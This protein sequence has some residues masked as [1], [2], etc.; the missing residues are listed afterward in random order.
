MISRLSKPT[1][2]II[3]G[4][5]LS[6]LAHCALIW[7][8]GIKF[9]VR[10]PYLPPLIAKLEPLPHIAKPAAPDKKRR[11]TPA[12]VAA[13]THQEASPP[14]A[15]PDLAI[16]QESA[17]A[18]SVVAAASEVVAASTVDS[19]VAA[20]SSVAA[21]P[22]TPPHPPLP[23]HARLKFEVRLGKDGMTVGEAVHTLDIDDDHYLLQS[24]TRTT[25]L[26]SLLKTYKLTQTSLGMTDGR[27]LMPRAY[28][29]E[30][31]DGGVSQSSNATFDT[32][33][34]KLIFSN[35]KEVALLAHTQDILSIL[36]QFP[37]ELPNSEFVTLS[38]TNGRD[39][40]QYRFE[41][42]TDKILITPL[43]K[44][45]TV[46]FRKMHPDG[47]EGLEIW[48]AQEYRFLPVKVRHIASDGKIGGEA[49]I[50]DIRV[51]D[52]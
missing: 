39:W 21:E 18:S 43:G 12:P 46:H 8:P 15:L 17:A 28:N 13:D 25:G 48:F 7:L 37:P 45:H 2:R 47:K 26:A 24:T 4:L 32:D 40:E 9:P 22:V 49:V 36:Y 38:I 16:T 50:T 10:E 33:S 29:E 30:K 31:K 19:A 35:G 51:A 1:Q 27:L 14:P 5:A 41:I 42:A 52:N 3:V 34:A 44:L 6:L 23:K 20:A 11:K